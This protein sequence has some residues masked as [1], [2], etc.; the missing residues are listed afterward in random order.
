MGKNT[1]LQGLIA[2]LGV[3]LLGYASLVVIHTVF[4]NIVDKLDSNVKNE[5]ARYKIGQYILRE[6]G[7]IESKY[8]QMGIA[9]K[10]RA[11]KPIQN[12]VKEEL[13]DIKHAINILKTGGVLNNYIKLNMLGVSQTVEKIYFQPN[14]KSEFTFEAI[15]L[16]PK[17]DELEKTL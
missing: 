14:D 17:L 3:F 2:L 16:N 5:Y 9:S 8:Y 12:E 10:V 7:S 4:S 6:I 1:A 13:K 11:L 15:D